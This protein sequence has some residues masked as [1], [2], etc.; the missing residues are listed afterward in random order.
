MFICSSHQTSEERWCEY[1]IVL[2][3]FY[4]INTYVIKIID[5]YEIW[6]LPF[7]FGLSEKLP[8]RIVVDYIAP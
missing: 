3:S 2:W 5:S 8:D 7:P 1:T 6:W 4:D